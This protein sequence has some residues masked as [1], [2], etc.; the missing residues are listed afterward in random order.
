MVDLAGGTGACS[1]AACR[2]NPELNSTIV[3]F[4]N[5]VALAEEIVARAGLS[6]RIGTQPGDL[7]RD[8]WP[9]GDLML[10]SL[11]LSGF[12]EERQ[13]QFFGKCFD[14]LPSGGAIVVHDFLMNDDYHGPLLAGL[15]NLTSV[16]GV[17]LSGE[18]MAGRLKTA[19]F[20]N[21]EVREVIPEYTG[22]VAA[23]K[24]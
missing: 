1:I 11:C 17:P 12:S 4:P 24:P 21:P 8:D 23:L 20:V 18:D 16:E 19:G 7:S 14:K 22:L 15:Y 5:V 10:I 6:D 13:M 2:R 9:Q 3:D